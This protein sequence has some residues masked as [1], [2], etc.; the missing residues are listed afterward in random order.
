MVLMTVLLLLRFYLYVY[1]DIVISATTQNGAGS[2]TAQDGTNLRRKRSFCE[3]FEWDGI[4]V[5]RTLACSEIE[6]PC[7]D[8]ENTIG[9]TTQKCSCESSGWEGKPNTANCTH[10]WVGLLDQMIDSDEPAE[11]ISR[12]WAQFLQDS[13]KQILFGGDL[14]GSIEIGEKLLSLARVQYAILDNEEERNEKAIEFTEMY[15]EAGNELLSDRAAIVWMTLPDDVR[16]REVS[17]LISELEQSATLMAEFISEK[18]KRIE[19]NN[20]AFEVQ[21]KGPI[22][23][24]VDDSGKSKLVRRSH[25]FDAISFTNISSSYTNADFN[26]LTGNVTFSF[27]LSPTFLMPPLKILQQS[28]QVAVLPTFGD[29]SLLMR[30]RS[31]VIPTRRNL[32]LVAYYVF[33]SVGALL[34]TNKTTIA[35]SLIIGASVNDPM[36]SIPLPESHPVTFKFYHLRTNGV[37]NPRCVFWDIS[38]KIWSKEGC[39]TLR[40]VNDSTECS[41]THLTSFA[42]L[43]DI[44]GLSGHDKESVVNQVLNLTTTVGCIFS[45][46]CL[47][48][49]SLVFTCFRSLWSVRHMIHSNLCFCLLLAELVFVTSIDRTENR[50]IC[51]AVAVILHYFFLSAFCWMLLEGY[52]LYLM[53]VQVFE[54]E[55]GK[56][57]FYCLYAYGFPAIIV[58][59]TVGVAWSN[60]STDQYCWLNV[61]TP[62]IWAFAG[63]IAVVI[64]FNIVFLGVA[65][66][67]VLSVPSRHRNRMEQMLGWLK[68]SATLLCLLGVTWIFG[69]LMIIQ[70]AETVFAYIF[71][72]LNC[73]QGVFIF[74]IHV[75]LNDK[76]RSTLLR[77][78]RANIC[79]L[80]DVNTPSVVSTDQKFTDMMKNSDLSR[81]SSQ[82]LTGSSDWRSIKKEEKGLFLEKVSSQMDGKGSPTTMI[83]YLDW[84]RKVS[85]DSIS[86]PSNDCGNYDCEKKEAFPVS[87]DNALITDLSQ[88]NSEIDDEGKSFTVHPEIN[89]SNG[90]RFKPIQKRSSEISTII[91][92]F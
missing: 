44:T 79:C 66:R 80:S 6:I 7:P 63:P 86:T 43:M 45:I 31:R 21:M 88:E 16:I 27:S 51:R 10:K 4:I 65:L 36:T 73:L 92:R 81:I 56:T 35:N 13:V 74:I 58:A 67:V 47:S 76:V 60:Y 40:T 82:P 8:P 84:K 85:N 49:T 72:I 48:L 12:K 30:P 11:H 37:N 22:P 77:F 20:W 15:G 46:I 68:G 32:L 5:P 59:I 91:E 62:T 28:A 90:D 69:Y 50:T 70:G 17:S 3:E 9:V 41:C 57:V 71:T 34:N 89:C 83:T 78:L 14:V 61:A 25:I 33:R 55:E 64:V 39:K 26:E 23:N 18:Q 19:Y 38:K 1:G 54:N 52:Q 53:L 87:T 75:V 29:S 24:H 2:S 42:I